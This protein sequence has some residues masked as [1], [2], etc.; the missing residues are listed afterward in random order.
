MMRGQEPD[1]APKRR[2]VE[3]RRDISWRLMR[4]RHTGTWRHLVTAIVMAVVIW[5]LDFLSTHQYPFTLVYLAPIVLL[6]AT[7]GRRSGLALA[8]VCA[9]GAIAANSLSGRTYEGLLVYAWNF[10]MTFGMFAIVVFSLDSLLSALER[11]E[12]N[13]RTDTLTGLGNRKSFY[14]KANQELERCRRYDRRFS[15]VVLDL[16]NFKAVND[17]QGHEAGDA[18]LREVALATTEAVRRSDTTFRI[19]GDEFV[20]LLLE[21]DQEGIRMVGRKIQEALAKRMQAGSWPVTCSLGSV[22]CLAS[23]K[24]LDELLAQADAAMYEAKR[25]GKNRLA[26]TQYC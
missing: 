17:N 16:D 2:A 11:E 13:A 15:L 19:G 25:S 5:V 26:E 22:S 24:S 1:I 6:T 8:L 10:F 12:R 7:W 23:D 18:V 3:N 9:G 4:M 21:T 14:E 20:I